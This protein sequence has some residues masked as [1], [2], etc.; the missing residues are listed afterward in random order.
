MKIFSYFLHALFANVCEKR[1]KK[2]EPLTLSVPLM[3]SVTEIADYFWQQAAVES[4][5]QQAAVES[6]W[7]QAF[8]ESW[9]Q[10][11]AE[12][13]WQQAFAESWQQ[14]AVSALAA[15]LDVVLPAQEESA[16]RAT[17]AKIA[18]NFFIIIVL[19]EF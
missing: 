17:T 6:F 9:Q 15:S 4:A 3:S 7:Q 16:T 11:F 14:A 18:L 10:A 19:L 2:E 1:Q 5:L 12:S 8:V 13:A